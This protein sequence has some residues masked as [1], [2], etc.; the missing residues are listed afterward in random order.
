MKSIQ[1]E[2]ITVHSSCV[3][4]RIDLLVVLKMSVSVSVE[5][6]TMQTGIPRLI[7]ERRRAF[8]LHSHS[9]GGQPVAQRATAYFLTNYNTFI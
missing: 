2:V 6:G 7:V 3:A 9:L 8:L 1:L 4:A 5:I